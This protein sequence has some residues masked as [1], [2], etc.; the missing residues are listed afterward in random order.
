MPIWWRRARFSSSRATRE[1]KIED[2]ER[3]VLRKSASGENYEKRIIP[4]RS[5]TSWFSRGTIPEKHGYYRIQDKNAC[6]AHESVTSKNCFYAAAVLALPFWENSCFR[7][8]PRVRLTL[9]MYP[10]T[11]RTVQARDKPRLQT[12][13]EVEYHNLGI[14]SQSQRWSPRSCAAR[15]ENLHV[16]DL[17]QT[18]HKLAIDPPRHPAPGYELP[19]VRMAG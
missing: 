12:L 9:A 13:L 14:R 18:I 17:A 11:Q 15:S 10:E 2:R 8:T 19:K 7:D 4:V 16:S 1:R 3:A 6:S 5:E